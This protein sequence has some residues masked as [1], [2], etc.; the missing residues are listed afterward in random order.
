M[1]TSHRQA[2]GMGLPTLAMSAGMIGDHLISGPLAASDQCTS[3]PRLGLLMIL[4]MHQFAIAAGT[5][6]F[7][8]L[9]WHEVFATCCNQPTANL[10]LAAFTRLSIHMP[11]MIV[12][13]VVVDR[14]L[15]SIALGD[16]NHAPFILRLM[17]MTAAMYV[18]SVLSA[19]IGAAMRRAAMVT[20]STWKWFA[21]TDTS[22][23]PHN[24]SCLQQQS[25]NAGGEN[26]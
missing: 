22:A 10:F 20:N 11:I 12:G 23:T 9:V 25:L 14:L 7:F 5:L 4:D 18:L 24:D 6:G 26:T 13:M 2:L 21:A 15:I 16:E 19:V 8:G 3:V 1:K 17:I